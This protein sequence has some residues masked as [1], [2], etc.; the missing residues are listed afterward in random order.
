MKF[1]VIAVV[2]KDGFIAKYSGHQPKDWTSKEEKEKFKI[3]LNKCDLS[4]L[5]RKSHELAYEKLR[6]RIIFT[7]SV[8]KITKKNNH[9]FFNPKFNNFNELELFFK[10]KKKIAILGG[11]KI[12]DFFL[13]KKLITDIILTVEPVFFKNG[14]KLFSKLQYE[15]LAKEIKKLSFKFSEKKIILNQEGTEYFY[16]SK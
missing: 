3:D 10:N 14:L 13:E 12:Y 2:S 5:G 15:N 16:Y 7:S 8:K 6:K 4:I 9:V 11:T 1:I